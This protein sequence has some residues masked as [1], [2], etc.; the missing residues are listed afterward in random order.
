MPGSALFDFRLPSLLDAEVV[1]IKH[2][3]CRICATTYIQDRIVPI[4]W[5]VET[6]GLPKSCEWWVKDAPRIVQLGALTLPEHGSATFN[7]HVNPFPVA[8]DQGATEVNKLSTETVWGYRTCPQM[9]SPR[10]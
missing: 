3:E 2:V 4:F 9:C 8:M 10:Q 5:D 6:T 1:Y 7:S